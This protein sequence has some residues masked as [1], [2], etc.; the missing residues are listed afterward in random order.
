[1]LRAS[2]WPLL[3]AVA[4]TFAVCATARAADTGS[5]S[6]AVFDG[7]G[8]P[9]PDATIRISGDQLPAG[10]AASTGSNGTYVF[11]YVAPGVYTVEVDKPG[12]GR[13]TRSAVVDVGRD[14]Q[15]DFL[16]GVA[17]QEEVSVNAVVPVVDVRSTEVSF[18][19]KA[20]ALNALPLERTYRG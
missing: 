19:F 1:M 4:I 13:A 9:I 11:E 14:T 7:S 5:L 2:G 15:V 8:T 12:V 16:L 3:L 17:L 20:D 6:G 10:R 18:N